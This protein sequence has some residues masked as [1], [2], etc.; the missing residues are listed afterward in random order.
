[1]ESSDKPTTSVKTFLVFGLAFL[2]FVLALASAYAALTGLTAEVGALVIVA[3]LF[4]IASAWLVIYAS[5]V[6][7]RLQALF[8]FPSA[9]EHAAAKTQD[10]RRDYNRSITAVEGM[11]AAVEAEAQRVEALATEMRRVNALVGQAESRL[12]DE[13]S[14]RHLADATLQQWQDRVMEVIRGV[15]RLVSM[16]GLDPEYVAGAEKVLS[17]LERQLGPAGL[18]IIRPK[19]GESFDDLLHEVAGEEAHATLEPGVIAR[20]VSWGLIAGNQRER[21]KVL[22]VEEKD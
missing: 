10:L 19:P 12:A 18:S 7:V 4:L 1:L 6:D 5:L 16:D 17:S 2:L 9:V 3:A 21:S 15:E 13:I 22:L 20:A 14:R 11:Q 8:S